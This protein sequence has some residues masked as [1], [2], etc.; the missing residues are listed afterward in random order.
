[1]TKQEK[2][3]EARKKSQT[4]T[5]KSEKAAPLSKKI[6]KNTPKAAEI[7]ADNTARQNGNR[8]LRMDRNLLKNS[9]DHPKGRVCVTGS[10]SYRQRVNSFQSKQRKKSQDRDR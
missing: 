7:E 3:D 9:T 1:M 8:Q 10:D 6:G 4:R 5:G 2:G